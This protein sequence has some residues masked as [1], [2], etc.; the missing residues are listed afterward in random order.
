MFCLYQFVSLQRPAK[1]L[2]VEILIFDFDKALPPTG[3]LLQRIMLLSKLM[4]VIWMKLADIPG[5]ADSALDRLWQKKKVE[6]RQ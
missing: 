4:L 1:V 6:T 5:G 2:G 3:S